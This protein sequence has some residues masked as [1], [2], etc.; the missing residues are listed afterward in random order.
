MI[1][2]T[3]RMIK[4]F[5]QKDGEIPL[6]EWNDELNDLFDEGVLGWFESCF[7][8]RF[9]MNGPSAVALANFVVGV[10][11]GRHIEARRAADDSS[12]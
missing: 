11:I 2:V 8:L 3:E 6:P 12:S 7:D 1:K 9:M 5:W 4:E 10:K